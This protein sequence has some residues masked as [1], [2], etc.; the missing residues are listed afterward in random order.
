[1]LKH[2]PVKAVQELLYHASLYAIGSE[3]PRHMQD[4][5]KF[6]FVLTACPILFRL[7]VIASPI[8]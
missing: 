7:M 2:L 3:T 1:M 5:N 4:V 8:F 6:I